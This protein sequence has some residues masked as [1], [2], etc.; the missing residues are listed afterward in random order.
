MTENLGTECARCIFLITRHYRGDRLP[1]PSGCH[2][3]ASG[4]T[5]PLERV[6]P[7]PFRGLVWRYA[8]R[9]DGFH[10]EIAVNRQATRLLIASHGIES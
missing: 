1:L 4:E 6:W 9:F 3:R 10:I 2:S 8:Q 5:S 7:A